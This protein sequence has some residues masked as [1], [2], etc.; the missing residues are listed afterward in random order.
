[1]E[2]GRYR[3]AMREFQ[4]EQYRP[5]AAQAMVLA[6]PLAR[7]VRRLNPRFVFGQEVFSYGAATA[8]CTGCAR[9]LFPWGGDI[10]LWGE[11]SRMAWNMVRRALREV[12]LVVPSSVCAARHLVERYGVDAR[13]VAAVSWGVDLNQFRR[14]DTMARAEI[15]RAYGIDPASCVCMNCRR[16]NPAWGSETALAAFIEVAKS[17][18]RTHFVL[19]GGAGVGPQAAAAR[20]RLESLGLSRRFTLFDDDVPFDE[21]ARL[22]SVSDVAVSL[23]RVPDMRSSSVLAAAA[24][25][26]ALVLSEQA[27]YR[28]M[29]A[30]GFSAR[31]VPRDDAA[32]S[33][34]A[35]HEL[36]RRDDEREAFVRANLAYLAEHEDR[37]RQMHKLLSLVEAAVPRQT[38]R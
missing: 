1:L 4:E 21:C 35:I 6:R 7:L 36:L 20:R 32:A 29:Q 38:A 19:L 15:C 34:R 14:A 30:L 16:F 3:R 10:Y 37:Q 8:A 18:Q 2:A 5:S 13:R 11:S 23:M 25:Q 28:A 31:F 27:E 24:C 26:A 17:D 33:A 9:I 22:M 12:E